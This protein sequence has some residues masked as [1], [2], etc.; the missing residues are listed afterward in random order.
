M[1]LPWRSRRTSSPVLSERMP[2]LSSE[3][4][5]LLA[6]QSRS[7]VSVSDKRLCSIDA[8]FWNARVNQGSM[9]VT[10][11]RCSGVTPRR[12][13]ARR[14]HSRS[15]FAYRGSLSTSDS[16]SLVQSG[17]SHNEEWLV[18]SRDRTAF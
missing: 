3:K 7:G 9:P 11:D 18:I 12:R 6:S 1:S 8:I 5:S 4:P 13:A 14:A 15:S 10:S 16:V 2:I 17:S